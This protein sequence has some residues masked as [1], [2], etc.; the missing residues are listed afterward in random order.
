MRASE[1]QL[2]EWMVAGLDGDANA[3][4]CLLGAL[5]PLLRSFF[6]RRLGGVSDDV[7]DLVQDCL[8]AIHT[9]RATYDR[10]RPFMAWTYG[11]ARYKM[12][13]HFRQIRHHVAIDDLEDILVTEGFEDACTARIDVTKLLADLPAKQAR[14]IRDTRIGGMSIAESAE[15]G[16]WS[17]SDVK[18]S[19]HRGL[20]ALAARLKDVI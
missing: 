13:D 20:K 8:M 9:R 5:V 17:E 6:A 3:Y 2:R 11:V 7:E 14:A 12:I 4:S 10:A 15:A 18:V 1:D 16:G 19:V